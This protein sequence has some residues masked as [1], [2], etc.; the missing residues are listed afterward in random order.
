LHT[1]GRM[2]PNP[3]VP[4]DFLYF[5]QNTTQGRAHWLMS[6]IPATQEAEIRRVEFEVSLDK[7]LVRPL[8]HPPP[9]SQ[10]CL[11]SQLRRRHK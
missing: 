8:P 3:A 11:S 10:L 2:A 9:P 6:V 7:K 5:L 1:L 4:A